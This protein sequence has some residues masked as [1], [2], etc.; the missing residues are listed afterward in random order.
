MAAGGGGR[1]VS[2]ETNGAGVVWA[3][4]TLTLESLAQGLK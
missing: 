1:G 2:K 4:G 3:V